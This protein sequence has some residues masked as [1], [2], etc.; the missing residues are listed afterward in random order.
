MAVVF[1]T[2]PATGRCALYNEPVLTGDPQNPNSARNAPLNSAVANWQN[3]YFHSDFNYMG[4]SHGPTTVSVSHAAVAA[5]GATVPE[6]GASITF[7]WAA[8][9]ADHLVLTHN[10]GYIPNAMVVVNGNVLWPGMPVQVA[11]DGGSRYV[12]AYCTT[13]QVRLYEW[14]SSGATTLPAINLSYTVIVFETPPAA[15]GTFLMDFNP[16]SGIVQMGRG[17]FNSGKRYLQVVSGGTPF[18]IAYGRTIDLANGAPRAVRPDGVA[19]NPVPASLT[20]GLVKY[21]GYP[22]TYGASMAYN[23]SF[24]GPQQIQVQ[25]P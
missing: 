20:L 12:S 11:S 8:T 7:G 24:A 19:Y 5:G 14:A 16:T 2:D 13:T 6:A 10:L 15:S 21:P 17:K 23:G 18:G 25:A 4:V 9:S 22:I 3:I 1:M